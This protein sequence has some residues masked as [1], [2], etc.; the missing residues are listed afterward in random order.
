M[1]ER[2]IVDFE[3]L[4][5]TN[6]ELFD[7]DSEFKACEIC[8]THTKAYEKFRNNESLLEL[9]IPKP[10]CPNCGEMI[11]SAG[12]VFDDVIVSEVNYS[13]P[14]GEIGYYSTWTCS[15]C[16]ANFSLMPVLVNYNANHDIFYTGGKQYLYDKDMKEV[17]K[18]IFDAVYPSIK[19][20]IDRKL[21]P[22]NGVDEGLDEDD[23]KLWTSRDV[24][25]AIAEIMYE[26]GFKK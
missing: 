21:N 13:N 10:I 3:K 23:V 1:K 2:D 9:E 20:Y 12:Y 17:S 19:Q 7:E 4:K 11:H 24:E 16:G 6:P 14:D 5:E 26:H 8:Y 15:R 18:K 22:K 25:Q